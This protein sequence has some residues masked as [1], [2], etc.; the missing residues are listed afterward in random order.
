MPQQLEVFKGAVYLHKDTN[1]IFIFFFSRRFFLHFL[2]FKLNFIAI[3]GEK[4]DFSKSSNG[5]MLHLNMTVSMFL[6]APSCQRK[7]FLKTE[8]LS[9]WWLDCLITIRQSCPLVSLTQRIDG[10]GRR[11][12]V[13]VKLEYDVKNFVAEKLTRLFF[14]KVRKIA[15]KI[16]FSNI[17][18][19]FESWSISRKS[20]TF[21][22]ELFKKNF[23]PIVASALH[24]KHRRILVNCSRETPRSF[25]E[26][27]KFVN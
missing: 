21:T 12:N 15:N 20:W 18:W 24:G 7:L 1:K 10:R 13:S 16:C 5:W 26:T 14:L 9:R 4:N 23:A 22:Q 3:I 19:V 8:N 2:T 6:F 17:C 27:V 25:D 11:T